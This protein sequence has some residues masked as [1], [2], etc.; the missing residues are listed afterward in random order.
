MKLPNGLVLVKDKY[1]KALGATH[2]TIAPKYDMPV[3]VFRSLLNQLAAR[4]QS[5]AA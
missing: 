3:E 5:G 2:Y 1:N 4:L